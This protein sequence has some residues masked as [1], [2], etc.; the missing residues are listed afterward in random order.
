MIGFLSWRLADDPLK[1]IPE[2]H[3]VLLLLAPLLVFVGL[4][5]FRWWA[6]ASPKALVESNKITG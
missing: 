6:V 3:G 1:E 5:W 4:Q 2:A